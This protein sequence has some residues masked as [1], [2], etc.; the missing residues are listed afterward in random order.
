M[1]GVMTEREGSHVQGAIALLVSSKYLVAVP[2]AN[3]HMQ[4]TNIGNS[5]ARIN[6]WKHGDKRKVRHEAH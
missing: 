2:H 3:K 6:S 4:G 1:Y 5:C